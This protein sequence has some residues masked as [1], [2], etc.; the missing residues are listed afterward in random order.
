MNR[1][2]DFLHEPFHIVRFAI[3]SRK[4]RSDR[5]FHVMTASQLTGS[6]SSRVGPRQTTRSSQSPQRTT[7]DRGA[8]CTAVSGV[9]QTQ[10][11]STRRGHVHPANN[12]QK[13]HN[14]SSNLLQPEKG[15]TPDL[16]STPHTTADWGP[17]RPQTRLTIELPTQIP[18]VSSILF[19]IAIQTEVTCSA[20]FACI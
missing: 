8:C 2:E 15:K 6:G 20:A 4:R 16:I 19:F 9:L 11:R 3:P 7:S 10:R 12:H 1:I 17:Q 13:R 5:R 18:I 14:E